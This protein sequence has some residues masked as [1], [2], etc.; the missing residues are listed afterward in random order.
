MEKPTPS[1]EIRKCSCHVLYAYDIGRATNLAKCLDRV[2][3]L[4]GKTTLSNTNRRAPKYFGFDPQPLSIIQECEKMPCIGGHDVSRAVTITLYDFGAIS[5]S[6]EITLAGTLE[7]LRD[8]S[9][10]INANNVLP[11][12][13]R[14]RAAEIA[15]KLGDAVDH[16][17]VATPVED[18]I[19]FE[20]SDFDLGGPADTLHERNAGTLA[21][22]LRAEGK[23][24]S[25][26][27]TADALAYRISY[28]PDDVTIIDWNAAIMFDRDADDVLS[29]LEFAN[30]ELLELRFL[31]Y[32]LDSSLDKSFELSAKPA[33]GLRL[34]PGRT[35]RN[36]RLISRMQL[37]GAILFER[38][39]N[40]PKLLG[41]QF[42]ARVYRL[43]S[44]RFHVGEWNSSILRKLD[45]IEDFYKQIH[46]A[47]A[48]QR[49]ELLDWIIVLLFVLE[50]IMPFF[51]RYLPGYH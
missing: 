29:V 34:L 31:D 35:A 9:I 51:Q 25:E 16:P 27:E 15:V 44:N 6:Y 42:L 41:D 7:N 49:L 28:G 46:D 5:I 13:S 3:E 2:S 45:T 22:V 39:S 14:R 43:A 10:Q 32:Q 36:V 19:I 33:A 21:Q 11:A 12:D 23:Q 37:E 47:A 26:S 4:G 48:G 8:L 40:A 30:T 50:I 1:V 24:L 18:Y 38:V 17:S 20:V